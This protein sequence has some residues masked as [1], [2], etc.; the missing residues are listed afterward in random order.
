MIYFPQCICSKVFNPAF[1][2]MCRK[3]IRKWLL[4]L[5]SSTRSSHTPPQ[6][7]VIIITMIIIY[8]H[9]HTHRPKVC[10][11]S[12]YSQQFST[13]YYDYYHL[14]SGRYTHVCMCKLWLRIHTQAKCNNKS[15]WHR[16][17]Y[18]STLSLIMI[19]III[20][21]ISVT[22]QFQCLTSSQKPSSHTSM[23]NMQFALSHC[24]QY[25]YLLH[26]I[27]AKC[28]NVGICGIALIDESV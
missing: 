2:R 12:T 24:M 5:I 16:I 21:L 18:I 8:L 26:T 14:C 3:A 6:M 28:L 9:S 25:S 13:Y 17:I 4:P 1:A 7:D 19:V 22:Y 15:T 27:I 10:A 20:Y 11:H 23:Q